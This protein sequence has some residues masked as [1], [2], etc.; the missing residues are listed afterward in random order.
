MLASYWN[1]SRVLDRDKGPNDTGLVQE[2]LFALSFPAE[3]RRIT[4][5][6]QNRL[7]RDA[8]TPHEFASQLRSTLSM[9]D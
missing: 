4:C 1:G 8:S 3:A 2:I 9:K 5:F 6:R 7:G